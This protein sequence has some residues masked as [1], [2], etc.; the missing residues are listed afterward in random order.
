[1]TTPEVLVVPAIDEKRLK[2]CIGIAS[3]GWKAG[4]EG[5][6]HAFDVDACLRADHDG[7]VGGQADNVLDLLLHTVGFGGG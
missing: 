6:K 1:M 4:D 3:R 5:L 7:V 2:R